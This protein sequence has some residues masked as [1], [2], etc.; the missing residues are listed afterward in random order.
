MSSKIHSATIGGQSVGAL[1]PWLGPEMF[2][3]DLNW[4][5]P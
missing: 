1:P 2:R 3:A 5:N 4:K